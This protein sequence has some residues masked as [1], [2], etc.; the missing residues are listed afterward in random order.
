MSNQKGRKYQLAQR[1]E[2]MEETRARIAQATFELHGLV[3]P[4]R[5][6]IAAIAERAGVERATVYRHFPDELS[7]YHGCIGHGQAKHPFPDISPW[8]QITDGEERLR[9]ALRAIY[10]FYRTVEY[11]F[12]NV[13]RDLPT[14]PVF[15]QAYEELGI[16]ALY[17][18]IRSLL[19][20]PYRKRPRF[21]VIS[22]AIGHATDFKTW[23]SLVR[24]QGL[25]D[26]QAIEA[27]VA[28]VH[29]L[30]D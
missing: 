6:T 15:Q 23:Q 29:C 7:L 18:E 4:A 22:A 13:E 5:T 27:M 11:T 8:R 24:G 2:A 10:R 17:Q 20:E 9:V 28:M 14:M 3:G 12:T 26:R 19:S 16:F 1:A 30:A 25:S 21:K